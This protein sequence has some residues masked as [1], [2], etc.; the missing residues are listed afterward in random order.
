MLFRLDK[1]E[2]DPLQ[3][4]QTEAVAGDDSFVLDR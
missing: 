3:L 1:A 2:V 4:T